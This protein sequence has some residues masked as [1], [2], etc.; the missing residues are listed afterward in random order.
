MST[1]NE[2]LTAEQAERA[3]PDA[4]FVFDRPGAA[5]VVNDSQN[6]FLSPDGAGRPV[7]RRSVTENNTVAHLARAPSEQP[8]ART[9]RQ[10]GHDL[11]GWAC[12]AAG[13]ARPGRCSPAAVAS[14]TAPTN[15]LRRLSGETVAAGV[16]EGPG[17]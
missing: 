7:L 6:D 13:V 2:A 10:R 17:G 5:L 8:G 16:N 1:S 12:P 14:N 11:A 4:K 9:G 3:L 15:D